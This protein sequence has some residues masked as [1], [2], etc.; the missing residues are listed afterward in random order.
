M[1]LGYYAGYLETDL[2]KSFR[3][4]AWGSQYGAY[5][6][7]DPI[8]GCIS[9]FLRRASSKGIWLQTPFIRFTEKYD[10]NRVLGEGSVV[11]L[12]RTGQW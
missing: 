11:R 8:F 9:H 7:F 3:Y 4:V 5:I 1:I 2:D 10:W 12:S 6:Q